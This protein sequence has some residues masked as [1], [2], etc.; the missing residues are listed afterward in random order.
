MRLVLTNASKV[1]RTNVVVLY[2][3]SIQYSCTNDTHTLYVIDSWTTKGFI[4]T[5]P[6]YAP[7][8]RWKNGIEKVHGEEIKFQFC[9][10]IVGYN[11]EANSI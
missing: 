3:I 11:F 10:S 9:L 6:T 1:V 8:F 4:Y 5:V 2:R 7:K